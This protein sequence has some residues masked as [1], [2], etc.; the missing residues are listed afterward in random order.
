V[1]V[2]CARL[3]EG[4][5]LNTISVVCIARRIAPSSKVL[6][7]QFVGRCVRTTPTEPA[8]FTAWVVSSPYFDQRCNFGN[9]DKITDVEPV[10]EN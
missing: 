3:L 5:D 1:L 10:E 6:F 9:F 2:V 7:A 4:F 8:G